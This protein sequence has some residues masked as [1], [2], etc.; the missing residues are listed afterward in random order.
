MPKPGGHWSSHGKSPDHPSITTALLDVVAT[1]TPSLAYPYPGNSEQTLRIQKLGEQ[2]WV[3]QLN[4]GD[5]N[6][7]TL[8]THILQ[9]LNQPYPQH[10]INLNGAVN[11]GN[12]IREIIGSR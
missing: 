12:K 11:I 6:P 5:L 4:E 2:G 9:A 1:R 3:T 8:K 10:T 7:Q